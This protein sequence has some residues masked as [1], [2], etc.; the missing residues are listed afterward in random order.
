MA[1]NEIKLLLDYIELLEAELK[2]ANPQ[3]FERLIQKRD[4][5]TPALRSLVNTLFA[6]YKANLEEINKLQIALSECS[7]AL[8][9]RKDVPKHRPNIGRK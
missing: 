5:L 9:T 4:S 7:S 2:D 1:D 8:S 3:Q 6:A